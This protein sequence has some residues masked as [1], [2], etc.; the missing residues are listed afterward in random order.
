MK[1]PAKRT[2]VNSK[3]KKKKHLPI[4]GHTNNLEGS[5][6]QKNQQ[7]QVIIKH[8]IEI[9]SRITMSTSS[10]N[11]GDVAPTTSLS[12]SQPASLTKYPLCII[13]AEISP[14]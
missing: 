4:T 7:P 3:V 10:T 2:F 9:Q 6:T 1:F 11:S 12:K 8:H 14:R 5:I 13:G